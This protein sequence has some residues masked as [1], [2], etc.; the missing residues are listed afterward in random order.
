[1]CTLLFK[2]PYIHIHISFY[3]VILGKMFSTVLAYMD[4]FVSK[5]NVLFITGVYFSEFGC[6]ETQDQGGGRV[7]LRQGPTSFLL[8]HPQKGSGSFR[9]L[10]Y[11]GTNLVHENSTLR[12][13][14]PWTPLNNILGGLVFWHRDYCRDI[15]IQF[16]AL[17]ISF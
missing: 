12:T 17:L 16:T 9:Q 11:R 2:Y 10:S 1:M 13:R 14:T 6:W 5:S 4:L 7:H 8:R 15:K 3:S